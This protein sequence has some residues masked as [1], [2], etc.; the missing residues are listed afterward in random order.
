MEPVSGNK[1]TEEVSRT[2]RG[3]LA[4]TAPTHSVGP[5]DAADHADPSDATDP[6]DATDPSD[7]TDPGNHGAPGDSGDPAD[8]SECTGLDVPPG[9]AAA[10]TGAVRALLGLASAR[11]GLSALLARSSLSAAGFAEL[12]L[13]AQA[14]VV[15][16]H[17][18]AGRWTSTERLDVAS[19]VALLLDR[20]GEDGVQWL[21]A[22]LRGE[23]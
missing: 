2:L 16:E 21:V 1:D 20:Y 14:L 23:D 4:A 22:S 15:D 3:W 17:P 5:S 8:A 10:V 6:T 13:L 12:R 7:P 19:W 9:D 18:S 11:G